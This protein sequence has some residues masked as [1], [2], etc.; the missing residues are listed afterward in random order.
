M[1][2]HDNGEVEN[3]NDSN[4]DK[5]PELEDIGVEYTVDG[6]ILFAM[7]ALHAQIKELEDVSSDEMSSRLPHIL[8]IPHQLRF[9]PEAV[10]PKRR[11]Y[12]SSP[13]EANELQ[14]YQVKANKSCR[15]IF[16][17]GDWVWVHMRTESDRYPFDAGSDSRSNPFEEE[18]DDAIHA[19]YGPLLHWTQAKDHIGRILGSSGRLEHQNK[20]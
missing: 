2:L 16:E 5:M 9:V 11:T 19:S 18:G 13:D 7:H 8:N 15:F 6:E 3:E 17:S 20:P 4:S 10:I 12:K 1:I 14:I